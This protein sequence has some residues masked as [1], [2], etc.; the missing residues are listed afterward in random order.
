MIYVRVNHQYF[1]LMV[2]VQIK[3][4]VHMMIC[5]YIKIFVQIFTY[6]YIYV[7]FG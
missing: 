6:I 1:V 2:Y 3:S 5:L 7:S 4:S